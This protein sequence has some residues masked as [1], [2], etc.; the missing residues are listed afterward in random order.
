MQDMAV[1]YDLHHAAWLGE[2][3][4][5]VWHLDRGQDVNTIHELTGRTP[6]SFACQGGHEKIVRLLLDR[7]ADIFIEDKNREGTME[8]A[9]ACGGP[10]V[11]ALILDVVHRTAL[12]PS[13]P[14]QSSPT[15]EE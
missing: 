10:L 7:G 1:Q 9:E 15:I 13:E 6:I 11:M 2:L 14:T 5:V 3:D 8:W 12:L 4:M